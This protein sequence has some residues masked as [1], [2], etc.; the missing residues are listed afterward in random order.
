MEIVYLLGFGFL[1]FVG[2]IAIGIFA[3]FFRWWIQ[4]KLTGA[5]IGFGDLIGMTLRKVRPGIIVQS[6][7]MAVQSGLPDPDVTAK[8]LEAHYLAGGNVPQVVRALIAANKAKTIHLTYRE[9]T[10]IDLAGRD[11]LEAV[12]TSVYPRVIDCPPQTRG[13]T[14]LDAMAKDGI[15]LKVTARVTVRSNL[16]QLIGGATEETIMAR[17]GE[18]IVSAIGSAESHKA[19]LENPDMISKTVLSRRLD[20]ETAFEIVSIDIADIDVG[21]NIGARLRADQAE[22]DTQVAR[23]R[24]EGRRAEA[25]ATEQENKAEIERSRAKLVEAETQVP[26]SIAEGLESGSL[27]IMD[28]YKLRN[29][30]ADTEMRKGIAKAGG[31]AS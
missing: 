22:A 8:S 16:Q 13:R 10:A 14:T 12:Q 21:L 31:Q 18:G 25:V 3:Y 20:A 9:A 28:L 23:A 1:L 11:V 30:Q 7:I 27:G 5:G 4:S 17:V 24:S 29:I 19:V 2:M 15:Q 26:L 6:K